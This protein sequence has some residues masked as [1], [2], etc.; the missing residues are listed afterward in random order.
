MKQFI[1]R[2]LDIDLLEQ[3]LDGVI[4]GN[5]NAGTAT[6]KKDDGN[7][8]KQQIRYPVKVEPVHLQTGDR[9]QQQA[10]PINK[11]AKRVRSA[12]IQDFY[13]RALGG[14]NVMRH[15][16]A[17]PYW[18]RIGPDGRGKFRITVSNR[19]E[20]GNYQDRKREY[21]TMQEAS[22]AMGELLAIH[23]MQAPAGYTIW[24][25]PEHRKGAK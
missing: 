6:V 8:A 23:D 2:W 24:L 22:R 14:Y 1:K 11:T 12:S 10:L 3:R 21:Q 13:T 7:V 20:F 15:V 16:V 9:V 4:R 17:Q 25:R 19:T 5:A 18:Y